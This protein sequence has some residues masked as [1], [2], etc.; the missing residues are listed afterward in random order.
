MNSN[1]KQYLKEV[2]ASLTCPRGVKAIFIRQLKCDVKDYV[3]NNPD[4]TKEDL[5]REF[6]SPEEISA[7]F[8]DRDDYSA[9]LK[10]AKKR[11]TFWMVLCIVLAIVLIISSCYFIKVVN[12]M[13]GTIEFSEPYTSLY[14]RSIL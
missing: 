6:G 1:V 4:A 2:A 12:D 3:Q 11:A 5:I 10:K 14:I 13:S 9:M 7:G 8:F